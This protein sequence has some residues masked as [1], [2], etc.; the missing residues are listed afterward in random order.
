MEEAG[1]NL[2][3]RQNT[4]GGKA[5]ARSAEA[6]GGSH[7]VQRCTFTYDKACRAKIKIEIVN[8]K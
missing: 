1:S 3:S 4:R 5:V 2:P 6:S 8:R 7:L